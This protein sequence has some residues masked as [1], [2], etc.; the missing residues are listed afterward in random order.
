MNKE[1]SKLGRGLS[2]LLSS[3][4]IENQEIAE[5]TYKLINISSI[6]ANSQQPRKNFAKDELED[7]AASIKSKGVPFLSFASKSVLYG[8]FPTFNNA[9]RSNW[10]LFCQF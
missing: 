1:I 7:L 9:S 10:R 2:S 3:S 6:K 5:K 8:R 4:N